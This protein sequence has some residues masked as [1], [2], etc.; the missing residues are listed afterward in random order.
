M[1]II[2]GLFQGQSLLCFNYFD[3]GEKKLLEKFSSRS[4]KKIFS[5]TLLSL[6]ISPYWNIMKKRLRG[7]LQKKLMETKKL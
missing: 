7:H 3:G 4:E 2:G 5:W 1:N 6:S